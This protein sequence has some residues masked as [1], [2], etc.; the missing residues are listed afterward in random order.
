MAALFPVLAFSW[1]CDSLG[2][3]GLWGQM[4][5]LRAASMEEKICLFCLFWGLA[6]KLTWGSLLEL[7]HLKLKL[8]VKSWL[9]RNPETVMGH[10][11]SWPTYG[12][13]HMA[14]F[15]LS[16]YPHATPQPLHLDITYSGKEYKAWTAPL[17]PHC[18]WKPL[19]L[20]L[21]HPSTIVLS[22]IKKYFLSPIEKWLKICYF[23]LHSLLS[24]VG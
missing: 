14:K 11:S 10:L 4:L 21:Y 20:A 15:S 16:C 1:S 9:S 6:Q 18:G 5:L 19:F 2:L 8:Y 24:V 17:P 23:S 12:V 22:E 3:W 13:G 7:L